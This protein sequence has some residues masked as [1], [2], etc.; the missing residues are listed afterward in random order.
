MA[1]NVLDKILRKDK[2]IFSFKEI[3]IGER[4]INV[5]A[6]RSKL[7]YYVKTGQL[8]NVRRGIYA[9]DKDYDRLELANRIL[10]PSY[11][12]FETVLRQAGI[13]FQY[14]SQIFVATYQT[15]E[16]VCEG[17]TYVYRKIKDRILYDATGIKIQDTYSI[18]S[19]ERAFLD[20]LYLNK[21]YYFDNLYPLDWDKVYKILPIYKNKRM[22]KV[23]RQHHKKFLEDE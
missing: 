20:I 18:A 7:N 19:P 22:E 8:Y 13:I 14:Y 5:S 6:L 9:K 21:D 11:I 15:R 10:I 17:Q 2:T 23:V 3:A 1:K 4:R 16:I 12:S